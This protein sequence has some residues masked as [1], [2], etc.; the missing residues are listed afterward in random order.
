[1]PPESPLE[2]ERAVYAAWAQR[3]A[4]RRTVRQAL[5]RDLPGALRGADWHEAV[6]E[7]LQ[8]AFRAEMEAIEARARRLAETHPWPAGSLLTPAEMQALDAMALRLARDLGP[9]SPL[10]ALVRWVADCQAAGWSDAAIQQTLA[11]LLEP[12]GGSGDASGAS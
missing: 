6:D 9:V 8:L 3:A 7:C 2:R 1:M 12:R 10:Q 11:R 4:D 5:L